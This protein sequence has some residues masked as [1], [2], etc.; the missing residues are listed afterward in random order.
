[1][2]N[3]SEPDESWTVEYA[4]PRDLDSSPGSEPEPPEPEPPEPE[5]PEPEPP[6]PPEPEP[7]GPPEPPQPEPPQP[8]PPEP[9]PPQPEPPEPEPPEPPEPEPPEPPGPVG[10]PAV[11]IEVPGEGP[12]GS[13]SNP[14][15]GPGVAEIPTPDG[16]VI[17]RAIIPDD[18]V[19]LTRQ[20]DGTYIVVAIKEI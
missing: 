15:L 6:E 17:I 8:E 2:R 1:M 4:Q 5:P 12:I 16:N 13:A 18:T 7:P 9:E 14:E 19:Q 20:S 11:T 10:P 3:L